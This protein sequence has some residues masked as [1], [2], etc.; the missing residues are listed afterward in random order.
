MLIIF[1]LILLL[2]SHEKF[3]FVVVLIALIRFR[4]C[5][6]YTKIC[7][8][9]FENFWLIYLI[10][11]ADI[12]DILSQFIKKFRISNISFFGARVEIPL[13]NRSRYER[14]EWFFSKI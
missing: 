5:I 9:D 2:A 8:N 13:K 14:F 1:S 10:F 11:L 3:T 7:R 4:E 6:V 12:P